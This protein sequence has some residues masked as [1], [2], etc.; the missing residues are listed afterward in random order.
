M[1]G[2]KRCRRTGGHP[3]GFAFTAI[4][5]ATGSLAF[6]MSSAPA[7]AQTTQQEQAMTATAS[8]PSRS[9]ACTSSTD[10]AYSLCMAK[11]FFNIKSVSCDCNQPNVPGARWECVGTAT[12]KK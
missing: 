11:G 10:K 2:A 6:L 4:G 3:M 5:A 12:C 9:D 7:A 8:A 1:A